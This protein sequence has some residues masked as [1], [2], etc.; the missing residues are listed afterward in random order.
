[1]TVTPSG[2]IA[3]QLSQADLAQC[4][5]AA[6]SLFPHIVDR[7]DL[8]QRDDLER[9]IDVLMGEVAELMAI[10]WL[11][12]NGKFAVSAVDKTSGSPDLGHDVWVIDRQSQRLAKTSIKSS[13][14]AQLSLERILAEMKLATK[15]SE[16]R[17]FNMQVYF[18]LT[19]NPP[20]TGNP[21]KAGH[22]IV[23]PTV[24]QSAIMCWFADDDLR[25]G[26]F[27]A[28]NGEGREAPDIPLT[29]GRAMETFLDRVA[30]FGEFKALEW[31]C[32]VGATNNDHLLIASAINRS[33]KAGDSLVGAEPV[34][35]SKP[36]LAAVPAPVVADT[37]QNQPLCT[38]CGGVIK[39]QWYKYDKAVCYPC[40][41]NKESQAVA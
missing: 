24:N 3:R 19:I 2:V 31:E 1:M 16:L 28:Y 35:Q 20:K 40:R 6:A 10:R 14:S 4:I 11:R 23:V 12:D 18:W 38:E 17:D 27:A 36:H 7:K 21:P 29:A 8:H 22:R 39:P 5:Q 37:T 41:K 34:E 26:T 9:F 32:L 13:I 30:D 33:P 25:N 15:K